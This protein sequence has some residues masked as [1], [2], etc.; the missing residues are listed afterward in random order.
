MMTNVQGKTMQPTEEKPSI[1]V[2]DDTPS[3]LELLVGLLHENYSLKLAH[4]GIQALKYLEQY[5]KLD[6][7]LLDVM[8]P[9]LDG[10]EVCQMIKNDPNLKHIPI[11]FITVL[12]KE[13]DVLRGF[14]LGAVDYVTKP[15][16]T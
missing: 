1:L 2:V 4:S 16:R 13:S 15:V 10:F 8:M 14:E 7:I 12:E 9:E 3:V 11:I 5:Q 6:L